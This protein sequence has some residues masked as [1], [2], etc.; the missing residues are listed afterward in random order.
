MSR[1]SEDIAHTSPS[2]TTHT[3]LVDGVHDK[4]TETTCS[5]DQIK[6]ADQHDKITETSCS[7]DLFKEI[8]QPVLILV[9]KYPTIGI[10]KTRLIPILGE[11]NTFNLSKSMLSDLLNSFS[12]SLIPKEKNIPEGKKIPEGKNIPEGKKVPEGKKILYLPEHSIVDAE[13]FCKLNCD[14]H[15]QWR[16]YPMGGGTMDLKSSNL[17]NILTH[18][19]RY[20]FT[21]YFLFFKILLY[22][23]FQ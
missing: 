18:A 10:S 19:L 14:E 2:D 5:N 12:T 13:Q 9:T 1:V 7:S 3:K 8:D 16:T 22:R 21:Q 15:V 17:T 6:M 20:F 4:I 23:I 11:E